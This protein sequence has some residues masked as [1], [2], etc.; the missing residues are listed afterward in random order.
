MDQF[1]RAVSLLAG[2]AIGLTACGSIDM[3][4]VSPSVIAPASIPGPGGTAVPGSAASLG[5]CVPGPGAAPLVG[6]SVA[7]TIVANATSVRSSLPEGLIGDKVASSLIVSVAR[8]GLAAQKNIAAAQGD[9]ATVAAAD[10]GLGQVGEAGTLSNSDFKAFAQHLSDSALNPVLASSNTKASQGNAFWKHLVDYYAAYFEGKFADRLGGTL[11]KPAISR[12]VSDD[13]IAGVVAVFVELLADSIVITPVWKDGDTFYP[14]GTKDQPTALAVG[15][16]AAPSSLITDTKACG[17][18]VLKA[19]AINLLAHAA[20]DRAST[21]GGLVS[22]SFGGLN[23]G[24]GVLGKFSFG[25]NQTLQVVIKTALAHVFA[26][27]AEQASYLVLYRVGYSVDSSL[28][29][30]IGSYLDTSKT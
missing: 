28:S 20:A 6:R 4:R 15:C 30:L 19:R 16:A 9:V 5:P 21:L 29:D 2:M 8:T 22:G 23:V 10:D 11:S 26:R 1:S 18:T 17:I 3:N 24:L 13:E 25:D 14:A 27:A 12:T 7:A